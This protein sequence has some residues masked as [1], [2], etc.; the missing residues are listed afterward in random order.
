[1]TLPVAKDCIDWIFTHVPED[2]KEIEITLIGGEP[3]LQFSLIQE[4]ADYT[5]NKYP[6]ENYIFFT[7]TNGTLLTPEMKEWFLAHKKR[8][9]LGLSLDGTPDTHNHNRCNSFES[10]DLDFFKNNWPGQGVKMTLT[11]YSLRHLAE[12]IQYLHSIGFDIIKGVNL[13]EG[14]FNWDDEKYIQILIPQL[15][16]LVEFYVGNDQLPINQILD[17]KIAF[18]ESEKKK[19]RW[20]G[21]GTR[22]L[23]FDVDGILRPCAFCTPMTFDKE[24]L[25]AICAQAAAKA[26]CIFMLEVSCHP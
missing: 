19:R 16:Q 23:F 7:V 9:V 20:C 22:A 15:A 21:I 1:M 24:D 6:Q 17:R 14:T 4:I 18:C 3:L 10:I 13:F 5:W 2:L 12:N 11:E 26:V 25:D 8:F